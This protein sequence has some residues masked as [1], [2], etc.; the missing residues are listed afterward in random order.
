M[1]AYVSY[2][3]CTILQGPDGII[4]FSM[5]THFLCLC[6]RFGHFPAV[7][8]VSHSSCIPESSLINS[9]TMDGVYPHTNQQPKPR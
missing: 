1:L 3:E 7:L 8:T 5:C 4:P 2:T 9:L 6:L